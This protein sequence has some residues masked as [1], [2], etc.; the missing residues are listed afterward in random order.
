MSP[1]K[2]D[3]LTLDEFSGHKLYASI[4]EAIEQ[5]GAK[6][7]LKPAEM[8]I[9]DWGCGRGRDALWLLERGYNA[10]GVDVDSEPINNG[11]ALYRKKGFDPHRLQVIDLS[12]QTDFADNFFQIIFSNQS[13]EHSANLE[14]TAAEVWRIT[15]PGGLG[16]HVF[17]AKWGIREGHLFMPLVHW[18]PKNR[19]RWWWIRLWVRLGIE[20][21]WKE[22]EGSSQREKA[23]RY[24]E[25]INLNTYYRTP[26]KI[27]RIFKRAGFHVRFVTHR[28]PAVQRHPFVGTLA[29]NKLTGWFINWL[30][31]TF[32]RVE[33]FLEKSN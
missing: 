20:P 30:L 16:F 12:A 25:Y 3:L 32:V 5:Y 10:Y 14:E 19:L 15:A 29:R 31:V 4:A 21:H 6:R 13:F 18:L 28:A 26:A 33:L 17:P 8:N 9:L 27:Q 11:A 24:Y 1:S 7:R 23:D 2:H 22:L